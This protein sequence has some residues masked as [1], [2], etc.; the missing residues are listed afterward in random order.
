MFPF[1]LFPITLV[2]WQSLTI[3]TQEN[4]SLQQGED[5]D[6]EEVPTR[7]EDIENLLLQPL[8]ICEERIEAGEA[9]SIRKNKPLRL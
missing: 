4:Y 5:C 7:Q 2:S 1:L 8:V 9:C 6:V 3:I